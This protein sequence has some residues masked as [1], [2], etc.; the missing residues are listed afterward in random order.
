MITSVKDLLA[1]VGDGKWAKVTPE[2]EKAI[3]DSIPG[4][5]MVRAAA[6]N[7]HS[8]LRHY[9]DRGYIVVHDMGGNADV[10][11]LDVKS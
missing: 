5:N 9:S 4:E 8:A 11:P 1:K 6:T 3:I 7:K 10:H 2:E